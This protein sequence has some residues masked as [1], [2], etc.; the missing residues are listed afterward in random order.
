MKNPLCFVLLHGVLAT[1]CVHSVLLLL[2][3]ILATICVLRATG[4]AVVRL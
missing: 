1:V 3:E 2:H 4:S